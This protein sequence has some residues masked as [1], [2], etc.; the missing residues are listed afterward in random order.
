[1]ITNVITIVSTWLICLFDGHCW[2]VVNRDFTFCQR[3]D[4]GLTGRTAHR[5]FDAWMER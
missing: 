5:Y 1:M 4:R 3:C 2:Q